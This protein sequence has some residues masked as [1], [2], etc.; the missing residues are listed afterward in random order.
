MASL[1]LRLPFH[2]FPRPITTVLQT[3]QNSGAVLH[4]LPVSDDTAPGQG[5]TANGLR[6]RNCLWGL[7]WCGICVEEIGRAGISEQKRWGEPYLSSID[8]D[9][10]RNALRRHLD[11][12]LPAVMEIITRSLQQSP[13]TTMSTSDEGVKEAE[14]ACRCAE[15]WIG[16]GLGGE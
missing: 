13:N 1:I 6:L 15:S 10:V 3:L 4:S 7:E 9:G 11:Q 5:V 14:A 2:A 12:D 16:Y 8:F